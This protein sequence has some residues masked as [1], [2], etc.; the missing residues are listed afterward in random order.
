MKHRWSTF[1]IIVLALGTSLTLV[2]S[3]GSAYHYS[4]GVNDHVGLSL[5]EEAGSPS[6][7][8]SEWLV[9]TE[10]DCQEGPSGDVM[11]DPL[12]PVN[13]LAMDGFCGA[14]LYQGEL[15]SGL[16]GHWYDNATLVD[17]FTDEFEQVAPEDQGFDRSFTDGDID[18]RFTELKFDVQPASYVGAYNLQASDFRGA[19]P[20][21][22]DPLAGP[23]SDRSDEMCEDH[24]EES[25]SPS[26]DCDTGGPNVDARYG[27]G[28]LAPN[29]A[30]LAQEAT[31]ADERMNGWLV[32]DVDQT[33]IAFL[34]DKDG[35]ISEE[36]LDAIVSNMVSESALDGSALAEVCGFVDGFNEAIERV[37]G[38]AEDPCP[39]TFRFVGENGPQPQDPLNPD[40]FGDPCEGVLYACSTVGE[41][42]AWYAEWVCPAGPIQP[43]AGEHGLTE[44][45]HDWTHYDVAGPG[46]WD[47]LDSTDDYR[48]WHFV[49]APTQS[50]CEGDQQPGFTTASLSGLRPF[51]AYDLD[52]YTPPQ[53][54]TL[55]DG[56]GAGTWSQAAQ[57]HAR[58]TAEEEASIVQKSALVEPNYDP[59]VDAWNT[60]S[61]LDTSQK[62]IVIDRDPL[63]WCNLIDDEAENVADPW[64]NRLGAEL[65]RRT[66]GSTDYPL[67][68]H[69]TQ[70]ASEV[71]DEVN[72][73]GVYGSDEE[74]DRSNRPGPA[75]M[76]PQ[77]H[78]GMYFD[79]DDDGTHGPWTPSSQREDAAFLH[80]NGVFPMQ[81]DAACGHFGNMGYGPGSGLIQAIYLPYETHFVMNNGGL[82]A[83]VLAEDEE[84]NALE[85]NVY[86]F[87]SGHVREAYYDEDHDAHDAIKDLVERMTAPF[88]TEFGAGDVDIQ[89]AWWATYGDAQGYEPLTVHVPNPAGEEIS[90]QGITVLP[91]DGE[92]RTFPITS[93]GNETLVPP[94]SDFEGDDCP[95]DRFENRWSF[96]HDCATTDDCADATMVTAYT[97]HAIRDDTTLSIRDG[98]I[99]VVF[100][101]MD[102]GGFDFCTTSTEDQFGL[103]QPPEGCLRA[104]VDVDPI[105]NDA[106]RTT[107]DPQAWS[108]L[109]YDP[110]FQ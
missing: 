58:S 105:D 35:P 50:G 13:T 93:T 4:A 40:G 108:P 19:F 46:C 29:A 100:D 56:A 81:W 75:Y 57:E 53:S 86:L 102:D 28:V 91:E 3:L 106:S 77:G 88:E 42:P 63:P 44:A 95:S 70:P 83:S 34:Q 31:G 69:P 21:G 36:R 7:K 85:N 78:V 107:P 22:L 23:L 1:V 47:A 32:P 98:S 64:V 80:D 25:P 15:P 97:Y 99:D 24:E 76:M 10:R 71:E 8:S 39:V 61:L 38:H 72:N 96:Y 110:A 30:Q 26:Y 14:L 52:V 79:E 18:A 12:D 37:H 104:W 62:D 87:F 65:E 6:V 51:I 5:E 41:E 73:V 89:D 82:G 68:G 11:N 67:S 20:L 16:P 27:G 48:A 74:Q 90:V 55:N 49:V 109:R 94:D 2:A 54:G 66:V 9:G 101:P 59:S 17:D 103:P 33:F 60:G 45:H 92:S 43:V 84:G